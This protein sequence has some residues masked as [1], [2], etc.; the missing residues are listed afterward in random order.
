MSFSLSPQQSKAVKKVGDWY[1]NDS[2]IKLVFTLEG[3]AGTGKSTILPDILEATGL[4][5]HEIAFCAPTGKAAKI[6]GEKLRAQG[7]NRPPSTIHS[8]IYT[9]K[10]QKAEVLEKELA[11]AKEEYIRIKAGEDAPS[12][13]ARSYLI[14]LDKKIAILTKDLDRAY[15]MNDL[16]FSLNPESILVKEAIKLII[17]D[18]ASMVGEEVAED[19]VGFEVPI[20]A[21]GDPGQLPPVGDKPGFLVGSPDALLTEVHR[22]AAENPIIRIATMVRL[23]QRA[24]YGDYGNGVLI[25][26]R[27]KDEFTLDIERDAQIIV[28]TNKTRWKITK[29]IRKAAGIDTSLP[30]VGEPLIMCKNSR[31]HPN[32]VNGTTVF[33][34]E[35]HGD[36][37]DGASR[38][39]AHVR[40][41]DGSLKTMFA[42]QG[43]FEEHLQRE[44]NFSSA[45]KQSAFRSRMQ[46]N[47]IDFGW[48]IT[49]HKS[50]GSQWDEV[51]V[52]DESGSFRDAADQWLYTAVTRAAERL[53]IVAD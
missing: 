34:A 42:Y 14:E 26:P 25:V 29:K 32:L 41:E 31:Q 4:E 46:D 9:P 11:E 33:S 5:P 45:S 6:M 51:I 48:A 23:G 3:F 22:Q 27:D 30:M 21:M 18:E 36:V 10:Q 39:V 37:I 53:V 44:K 13:D 2:A 12:G 19:M 35:D 17:V 50:Q 49:C 15:D 47:H 1:K 7:I 24:E 20:L 43:L 28:G 52:H 16:R 40:D 8:L 38:F